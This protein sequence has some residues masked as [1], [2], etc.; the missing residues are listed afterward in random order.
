MPATGTDADRAAPNA[1]DLA[2][3]AEAAARALH[4]ESDRLDEANDPRGLDAP[5]ELGLHPLLAEGLERAGFGVHREIRYPAGAA[6]RKRSAGDRCDLVLTPSPG[7]HLA[8]TGL[9]GTLYA[10]AGLPPE[11]ACWI[12][13]KTVRQFALVSG[14]ASEDPGYASRLSGPAARDLKKLAAD[15]AIQRAAS[16]IILFARDEHTATRDLAAWAHNALDRGLP[17]G[18]QRLRGFP[19]TDRLGNAWCAVAVTAVKAR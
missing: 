10:T 2:D 11:R 14:V 17:A 12:E 9:A 1:Y 5:R 13:V 19:I 3:I 8:D 6:K 7:H 18:D 16:M 4:A 15:P